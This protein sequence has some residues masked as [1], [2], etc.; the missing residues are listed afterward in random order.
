MGTLAGFLLKNRFKDLLQIGNSNAGIDATPRAVEDGEGT[1][2]PLLLSTARVQSTAPFESPDGTVSLPGMTFKDDLDNGWY[3]TGANAWAGAI[4]GA[5]IIG[6]DA[7]SGIVS[8]LQSSFLAYNSVQDANVTGAGTL[9][10]IEFDTEAFDRNGDFNNTTDT[11]TAPVTGIYGFSIG[12]TVAGLTSAMTV[13]ICNLVTTGASYN[14]FQGNI[15]AVRDGTNNRYQIVGTVIAPMTAA[16]TAA[17]QLTVSNGAS[18]AAD[19][20]AGQGG[21]WF[22]G[23]LLG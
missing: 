2:S 4:G 10:T 7:A 11:F 22:A 14:I 21:T 5:K 23:W 8:P 17:V 1:A 15:G 18:D 16:D 19:I 9:V 3:R 6:F 12:V 13:G 20:N